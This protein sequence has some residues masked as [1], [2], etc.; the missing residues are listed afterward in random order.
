MHRNR[1]LTWQVL[2]LLLATAVLVGA[3]VAPTPAAPAPAGGEQ[4]SAS[5]TDAGS[6]DKPVIQLAENPWSASAL[7]VAVARILLERELGYEVEV[8][9][10]GESAQ[11][12]AIANGDIDASLE[13][14]PS[15]H[16]E[17]V[18]E[19]IDNQG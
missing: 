12:P 3:C 2:I 5:T 19:Y 11:W 1:K 6:A 17:N 16:A 8:V 9:T 15:G 18:A 13:V 7:N 10:I 14:W 4:T